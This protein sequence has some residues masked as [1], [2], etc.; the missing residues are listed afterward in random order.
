MGA[1]RWAVV[2]GG[3]FKAMVCKGAKV[4]GLERKDVTRRSDDN[5]C[6]GYGKVGLGWM[7]R[8]GKSEQSG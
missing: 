8:R 5:A 6:P 2:F 3:I 1:H 7:V 4:I